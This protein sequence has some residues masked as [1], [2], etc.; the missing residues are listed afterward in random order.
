MAHYSDLICTTCEI[1]EVFKE[2]YQNAVHFWVFMV[3][4][5]YN[6][7]K[8]KTLAPPR[9]M[10]DSYSYLMKLHNKFAEVG[11]SKDE[12]RNDVSIHTVMLFSKDRYWHAANQA[13]LEI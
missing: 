9:C 13:I 3:T 5:C 4:K 6:P 7:V 1:T 2:T 12:L 11:K 10:Q 8:K